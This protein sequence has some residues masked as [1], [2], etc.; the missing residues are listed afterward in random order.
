MSQK[1][2]LNAD[3]VDDLLAGY[4]AGA[5]IEVYRAATSG[6][7]FSMITTLPLVSGTEQYEYWDATGSSTDYYKVRYATSAGT[8]PSAYSA[9]F[10]GGAI[11]AYA[12]IDSLREMLNLPD[13]SRDNFL[14]DCLRRASG[15]LT[16][17]CG[18]DFYRH[19]QVSGT[20]VRTYNL[21][22]TATSVDDDIVSLTT[23]EYASGTGGTFTAAVSTDY[24]L[25]PSGGTPFSSVYLSDIGLV[26][27]F[28]AGYGTVRLTGVFGYASVPTLIEQ[29]TLDLARE[30]Y[31]QGPGGRAVGVDFGRLP[32]S[33]QRAITKYGRHT[34]AFA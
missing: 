16:E 17:E 8:T 26:P 18:R 33:V 21:D 28:S 13:N 2:I 19:P 34:F 24:A 3:N 32:L 4:G 30:L 6:G 22:D 14:A 25:V 15:W 11:E 10:Q 27:E 12:S 23:V 29:A 1:V 20:E 31:Q 7:A 9:E 5:R